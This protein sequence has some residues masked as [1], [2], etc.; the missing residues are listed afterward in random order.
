MIFFLSTISHT[1]GTIKPP[2]R[3]AIMFNELYERKCEFTCAKNT[4]TIKEFWSHV[5]QRAELFSSS[6]VILSGKQLLTFFAYIFYFWV[7]SWSAIKWMVAINVVS[8]HKTDR[9]GP[10]PQN[11]LTPRMVNVFMSH[12]I[13]WYFYRTF[14]NS[15]KGSA[16]K[17]KQLEPHIKDHIRRKK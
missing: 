7:K 11:L 14:H 8:S 5:L 10:P 16:W 4:W 12:W 15:D 9:R 17:E 6:I 1:C 13:Y 2:W 3:A